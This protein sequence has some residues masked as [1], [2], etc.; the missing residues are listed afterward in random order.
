[1]NTPSKMELLIERL[2]AK[3]DTLTRTIEF[4]NTML[5]HH[6]KQ[7]NAITTNIDI[8]KE[9]RAKSI[10]NLVTTKQRLS[11]IKKAKETIDSLTSE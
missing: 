5:E 1:M 10:N 2:Q 4:H 9:L 7:I 11:K 8:R 6:W 3:C